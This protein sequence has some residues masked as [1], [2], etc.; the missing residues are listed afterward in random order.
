MIRM[1]SIRVGRNS[2]RF[3]NSIMNL[4]SIVTNLIH[5]KEIEI[6]IEVDIIFRIE[7]D[8]MIEIEVCLIIEIEEMFMNSFIN[9]K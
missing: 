2:N 8:M 5:R 6:E 3:R 4:N 7:V 1:R 9:S